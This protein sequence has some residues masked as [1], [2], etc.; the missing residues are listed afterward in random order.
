MHGEMCVSQAWQSM[1]M[2]LAEVGA[3]LLGRALY[4]S[5]RG[6]GVL[7]DSLGDIEESE[8]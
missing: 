8:T 3:M 2:M 1:A 6:M 4:L 5:R 7:G